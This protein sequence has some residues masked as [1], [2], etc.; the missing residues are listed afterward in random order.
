[1]KFS[2][3]AF[4]FTVS[5]VLLSGTVALIEGTLTNRRVMMGF[6]QHGAMWGDLFIM[7]TLAGVAVPHLNKNPTVVTYCSAIAFTGTIAAHAIW[8]RWFRH[9]GITGHIFPTYEN[10]VWYRDISWAGWCHVL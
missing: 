7:A 8:A 10:A 9:E 3:V 6:I 2:I 5:A 1:M 4:S